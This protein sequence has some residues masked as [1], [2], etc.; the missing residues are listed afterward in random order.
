MSPPPTPRRLA[1]GRAPRGCGRP[2]G[3]PRRRGARGRGPASR[4]SPRGT[5]R[6]ART[7]SA[8]ITDRWRGVHLAA[9]ALGRPVGL[10]EL[11]V[12]AARRRRPCPRRSRGSRRRRAPRPAAALADSAPGVE[13]VVVVE[14]HDELAVARRRCR[15]W[16]PRRCGRWSRARPAGCAGPWPRARGSARGPPRSV[17]SR[18]P[19]S[20]PSLEVLREH[21]GDRVAEHVD[22]RFVDRCDDGEE[23]C[24]HRDPPSSFRPARRTSDGRGGGWATWSVSRRFSRTR[25]P[26][27]CLGLLEA[28]ADVGELLARLPELP[29][30]LR[31]VAGELRHLRLGPH[32]VVTGRQQLVAGSQDLRAPLLGLR[33]LLG[34]LR[35]R[36]GLQLLVEGADASV[37]VEQRLPLLRPARR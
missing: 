28:S 23:R 13:Q 18:R 12:E 2:D 17:S 7:T 32:D 27:R 36:A 37:R 24:V 4:R 22:R 29:A 26:V 8:R 14:Q 15:R 3:P 11:V 33:D 20:T 6:R 1:S 19:G 25:R 21:R 16:T 10:A 9:Q 30:Q 31:V 35:R 5:R 34:D